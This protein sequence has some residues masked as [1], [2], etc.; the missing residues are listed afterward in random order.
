[1]QAASIE[2]DYTQRLFE[3]RQA[4]ATF[5]LRVECERCAIK[6][7]FI[8]TTDQIAVDGGNTH[9]IDTFTEYVGALLMLFEMARRGIENKQQ[10]GTSGTGEFGRSFFPDV[11]TDVD[12]ATHATQR[13][14]AGFGSG[15]E[16]A[17]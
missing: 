6:N 3:R 16:I 1:M 5:F 14:D 15:L 11:G 4:H 9:G 8:L 13:H 7:Q 12:A 10:L 2:I 17:A